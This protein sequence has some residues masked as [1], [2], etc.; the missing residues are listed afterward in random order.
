[1]YRYGMSIANFT[2]YLQSDISFLKSVRIFGRLFAVPTYN[3]A[4]TDQDIPGTLYH[5]LQYK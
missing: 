2:L 3:G 1:M 5:V 4:M